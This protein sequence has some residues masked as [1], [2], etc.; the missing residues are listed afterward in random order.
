MMMQ[1][2]NLTLMVTTCLTASLVCGVAGAEVKR[3]A[4]S[5]ASGENVKVLVSDDDWQPEEF[6]LGIGIPATYLQAENIVLDGVDNE[7]EW[8]A[9]EDITVPLSYGAIEAVQIKA[10]Y[11]A[12]DV[13]LRVRWADDSEDRQYRPWVWNED[14]G[15][16]E[17][18]PQVDD[19]LILS[20]EAGCDWF[21]S[22]LSGYEFDF[23]GW[24]WTAGRSDREGL[25]VDL[26]GSMKG[27]TTSKD[28]IGY[29]S[30]NTEREWNLKFSDVPDGIID[31]ETVYKTWDETDRKYEIWPVQ[32]DT[33]YFL[34]LV[35]G[36]RISGR[37]S[38]EFSNPVPQPAKLPSS[39]GGIEP[40]YILRD[41][42]D[43]AK[44]VQAKGQWKDGYWTVEFR[45]KRLTEAGLAYD[46]QFERLT[47]FSMHVFDGVE[48]L[49][50]S[51]ESPRLFLQFI[52]PETGSPAS[53]HETIQARQ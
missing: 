31:P 26:Y 28:E 41:L 10:L 42:T 47:Q 8:L 32:S 9:A 1:K 50:Q 18:G 29:A 49:D 7:A 11:T 39:P 12:E 20:F 51:S 22:L 40:Q 43:N 25:A 4:F 3:S 21:P 52:A 53:D 48:R 24:Y 38:G 2:Y 27:D 34:Y 35:D 37:P 45:R 23:D 17:T 16:Y 46:F 44:D 5:T 30:R 36:Q 15:N 19:A 13:L 33:M 14:K 6:D